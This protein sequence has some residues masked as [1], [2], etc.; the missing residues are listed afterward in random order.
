M[1]M[2]KRGL[3]GNSLM[4][5]GYISRDQLL[6]VIRVQKEEGGLFGEVLIKL[7]Y[8]DEKTLSEYLEKQKI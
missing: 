4:E 6:D 8:I 2:K 5:D 7:G 1:E 3:L